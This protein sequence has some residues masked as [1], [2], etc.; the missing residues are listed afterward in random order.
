MRQS[1]T[2]QQIPQDN[3]LNNTHNQI[4]QPQNLTT[5]ILI[6]SQDFNSNKINIKTKQFLRNSDPKKLRQDR[7]R[8]S[9]DQLNTSFQ[10]QMNMHKLEDVLQQ[11]RQS[12]SNIKRQQKKLENKSDN[13]EKSG[14]ANKRKLII[15][16]AFNQ[17]DSVS[18][19]D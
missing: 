10:Q 6:K 13:L 8:E 15:Q 11:N 12:V 7:I 19:W 1:S 16:E 2:G 17:N 14:S 18:G 5:Q 4:E 3:S 9:F